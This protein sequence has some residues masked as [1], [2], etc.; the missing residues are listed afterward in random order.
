MNQN[1]TV[2]FEVALTIEVSPGQ[3]AKISGEPVN[4]LAELKQYVTIEL[5]WALESFEGFEIDNIRRVKGTR[6]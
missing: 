5:G 3:A 4:S 6:P 2:V 1:N